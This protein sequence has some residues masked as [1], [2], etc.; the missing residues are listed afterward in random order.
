MLTDK[1]VNCFFFVLYMMRPRY[2]TVETFKVKSMITVPLLWCHN[3]R[4]S[5]SNHRHFY[6]SLNRL[7]RRR[8]KNTSNLC[9]TGL[10]AGNSPVIGEFPAQ[11]AS[12]AENVSIW[13]GHHDNFVIGAGY[14]IQ[15]HNIWNRVILGPDSTGKLAKF[16]N[17]NTFLKQQKRLCSVTIS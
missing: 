2:N 3:V 14:Y 15:Y 1:A 9:A 12:N 11:R 17:C 8:S 6:C 16:D 13:W 5:V 10:C 7:F 4:D